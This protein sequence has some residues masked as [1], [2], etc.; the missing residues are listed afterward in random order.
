[1]YDYGYVEYLTDKAEEYLK[2]KKFREGYSLIYQLLI[3][4]NLL[5]LLQ[6]KGEDK[7]F[8]TDHL[9]K[10]KKYRNYYKKLWKNEDLTD[11]TLFIFYYS[12]GYGDYIMNAR[13][14]NILKKLAG[15]VIIEADHN[16]YDL[17]KFNF[18][19]CEIVAN[20]E[21][22]L[23]IDYDYTYHHELF[24]G[25]QKDFNDMYM[26][27]GYLDADPNLVKKYSYLFDTQK[28]KVGFF[29]STEKDDGRSVPAELMEPIFRNQNCQ[30]YTLAL[31]DPVPTVDELQKKYNVIELKHYINSANDT[32]A[33]MKNMDLVISIDSFPIHLAG[34]MG[35][36]SYLM[37]CDDSD[38]RWFNDRETTP[39][40]DSVRIFKQKIR[41]RW[42]DVA[43]DI[44]EAIKKEF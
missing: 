31:G 1:M 20:E 33:L 14:I 12:C 24:A 44:A 11:K 28:I 41:D 13:Y 40:Y 21:K 8:I 43:I 36:K 39:W 38:W 3:P 22:E 29:I 7:F 16:I 18:P 42:E 32:A 35:V 5:S 37:L 27:E 26:S 34:A 25:L 10:I 15:K 23:K 30:F 4:D 2:K 19:D 9:K 6:Y 17:Y